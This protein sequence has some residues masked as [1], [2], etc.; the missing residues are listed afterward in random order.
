M[1]AHV[2]ETTMSGTISPVAGM[3]VVT[4]LILPR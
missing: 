4:I 1:I 3:F 2:P